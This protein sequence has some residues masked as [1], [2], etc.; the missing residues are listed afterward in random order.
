MAKKC[1]DGTFHHRVQSNRNEAR[2]QK[3]SLFLHICTVGGARG[4]ELETPK[5]L[6]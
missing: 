5:L 3:K 2:N 4:I 6:W 1:N